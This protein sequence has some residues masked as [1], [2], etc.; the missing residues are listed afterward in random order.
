MPMY[1]GIDWVEDHHDVAIVDETGAAVSRRRITDDA[2]GFKLLL[3]ILV[4]HGDSAAE[5][6]PV[7]IETPP[8]LKG[9]ASERSTG[10]VPSPARSRCGPQP[11]DG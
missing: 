8:G 6:T 5:P 1:C 4:Q 3:E 7:A 9:D 11:G 2:D 10:C